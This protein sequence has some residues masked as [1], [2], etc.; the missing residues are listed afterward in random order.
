LKRGTVFLSGP[1]EPL[2]LPR[3]IHVLAKAL[4]R[5][6]EKGKRAEGLKRIVERRT[7]RNAWGS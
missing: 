7:L 1:T 3:S 2:E 4:L 5:T 6:L